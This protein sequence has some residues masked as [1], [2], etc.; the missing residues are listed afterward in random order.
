[1]GTTITI[2]IVHDNGI[3][4]DSKLA[5]QLDQAVAAL[6]TIITGK[7]GTSETP[8]S[9][10]LERED[11]ALLYT[12]TWGEHPVRPDVVTGP[13]V[14]G[15]RVQRYRHGDGEVVKVGDRRINTTG[16][17]CTVT[18]IVVHRPA[19]PGDQPLVAVHY[20]WVERP[21]DGPIRGIQPFNIFV[22]CWRHS[23]PIR[24]AT[25]SSSGQPHRTSPTRFLAAFP[26]QVSS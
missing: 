25:K 6:L 12:L 16:D 20:T 19:I 3:A 14:G 1:M 4:G 15:E 2:G 7:P 21:E 9:A 24:F 22:E 11:T 18:D 17:I 13:D 10:S 23:R 8:R 5:R 26:V